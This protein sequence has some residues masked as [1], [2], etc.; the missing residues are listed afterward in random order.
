[1]IP[2]V[3]DTE[4]TGLIESK[5]EIVQIAITCFNSSFNPTGLRFLSYVKPLRPELATNEAMTINGLSLIELIK[6]APTPNQVRAS[7]LNWKEELFGEEKLFPL[8]HNYS[9]DKGFLKLF[10]KD[11]YDNMFH[12]K[13]RDTFIL[14]QS[15]RDAGILPNTLHTKL[16]QLCDYFKISRHKM[17]DAYYD[18][19][20]T[21]EIYKNLINILKGLTQN[22]LNH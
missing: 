10:L 3:I 9:F 11:I 15:M 19:I 2:V 8:G 14:V 4:T 21:L 18:T 5:H 17:H 13:F 22:A 12:Y 7:L 16:D 6:E 1:M 20:C